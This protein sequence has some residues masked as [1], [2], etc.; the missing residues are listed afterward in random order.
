MRSLSPAARALVALLLAGCTRLP[1]PGTAE[2]GADPERHRA[3][4]ATVTVQNE[5][6]RRLRIAFRAAVGP[7][8]EVV[9][10]EVG[11]DSTVVV[12]PVPAGEPVLLSAIAE[13]SSRLVLPPRSFDLGERWTWRISADATF[14]P[15]TGRPR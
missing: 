8:G 3:A 13:D 10:G 12:A 9:V 5:T 6:T 15:A 14:Q 2:P 11:A 7:G 1:A 4:L